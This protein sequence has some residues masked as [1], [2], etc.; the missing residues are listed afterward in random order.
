MIMENDQKRPNSFL[1]GDGE[2]AEGKKSEEDKY[3]VQPASGKAEEMPSAPPLPISRSKN[4]EEKGKGGRLWSQCSWN[5]GL[6]T[7]K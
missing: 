7:I 3:P 4:A 5:M 2:A 1:L 6:I